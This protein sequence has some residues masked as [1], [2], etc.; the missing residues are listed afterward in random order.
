MAK[1]RAVIFDMDGTLLDSMELIY[2]AFEDV[3]NNNGVKKSRKHIAAVT[4]KP[5]QAMYKLLAP[6]LDEL[7][8]EKQHHSHHKNNM[9]LLAAYDHANELLTYL[10]ERNIRMGIFTGFD[11]KTHDRL[12]AVGINGYFDSVVECT[13]YKNHKP[14]PEGLYIAMKDL[15]IKNASEIIYVGDARVDI[16]AGIKA[17]VNITIG[18]SHGFASKAELVSAGADYVVGSL[19]EMLQL[20]KDKE[21]V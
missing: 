3:L 5:V 20:F 14:D 19:S 13:R 18:V 2:R 11:E 4:G 17:G 10:K 9:H 8:M 16:E 6:K 1:I 21:L 12:L 7:E 15:G